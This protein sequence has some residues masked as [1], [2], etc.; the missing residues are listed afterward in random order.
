MKVREIRKLREQIGDNP[1]DVEKLDEKEIDKFEEGLNLMGRHILKWNW[2]DDE[3]VSMLVPNENPDTL[4]ELTN[5]EV[6]F[7]TGLLM[8]TED[9]SKNSQSEP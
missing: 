2:V 6:E 9:E 7:L 8:G 3:D 4:E 5:E 1:E